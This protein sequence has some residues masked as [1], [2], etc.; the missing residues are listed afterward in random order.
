[1]GRLEL[2]CDNPLAPL[3]CYLKIQKRTRKKIFVLQLYQDPAPLFAPPCI[4]DILY[5][6]QH[7][8]WIFKSCELF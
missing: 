6:W 5:F 1:M 8:D 3:Y 4:E 7:V 2:W